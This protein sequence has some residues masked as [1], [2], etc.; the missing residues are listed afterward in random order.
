MKTS[1]ARR[2]PRTQ[3]GGHTLIELL[4]ASAIIAV[5]ITSTLSLMR[6]G[7]EITRDTEQR[8]MVT[9][10]CISKLEERLAAVPNNFTNSTTTGTFAADGYANIRFSA[11]H[12]DNPVDGGITGKLMVVTVTVWDDA[13]GNTVRNSGEASV[14]LTSKVA[15]ITA[16]TS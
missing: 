10:L 14:T 7:M 13:N 9:T 6:Q 5:A 11:V 16:W 8:G 2:T 4:A 15:K 3:R 12:S 1:R